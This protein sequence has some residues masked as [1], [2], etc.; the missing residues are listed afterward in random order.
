MNGV[1]QT[2]PAREINFSYRKTTMKNNNFAAL[3]YPFI[4]IQNE[5][6]LKTALLYWDEIRTIV[7]E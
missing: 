2:P 3:Y 7:P 4:D 5:K 1:R 6:W